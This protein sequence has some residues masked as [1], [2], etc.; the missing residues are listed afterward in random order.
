MQEDRQ[1][2]VNFMNWKLKRF[3]FFPKK[4]RFFRCFSGLIP[5]SR[6]RDPEDGYPPD[7][8]DVTDGICKLRKTYN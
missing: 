5:A 4:F 8:R 2:K 3:R 6:T 7:I 1:A